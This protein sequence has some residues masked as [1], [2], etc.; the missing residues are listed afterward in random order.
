MTKIFLVRNAESIDNVKQILSEN[1]QLSENGIMQAEALSKRLANYDIRQ[2]YSSEL[3]QGYE[4]SDIIARKHNMNTV[5]CAEFNEISIGDW[6]NKS[7]N[8]IVQLFPEAW[9]RLTKAPVIVEKMIPGGESILEVQY[10]SLK[11]LND[12]CGIHN[13]EMICITLHS[14]INMI[15]ISSL[16]ELSLTQITKICQFNAALNMFEYDGKNAKFLCIND[17]SHVESSNS[18]MAQSVVS[19]GSWDQSK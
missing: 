8:E 1:S 2:F 6:E 19:G 17:T 15:I 10:R 18:V 9:N 5:R 4:T 14:Y 3:Q 11:K 13:N 16:L 7:K 12:L